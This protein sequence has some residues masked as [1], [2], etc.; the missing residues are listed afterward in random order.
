M[1]VRA[2]AVQ[3]CFA[4]WRINRLRP[5]RSLCPLTNFRQAGLINYIRRNLACHRWLLDR[6]L[7]Q[8]T[9]YL[10]IVSSFQWFFQK[11]FKRDALMLYRY[12]N[13]DFRRGGNSKA[14][15]W[16]FAASNC[17]SLKEKSGH[18]RWENNLA[19]IFVDIFNNGNI[20]IMKFGHLDVI[21]D[22]FRGKL[23][24]FTVQK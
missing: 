11:S 15:K 4:A 7:F 3:R 22:S 16:H 12:N 8:V 6:F 14:E 24:N 20:T 19:R 1:D 5:L 13:W 17:E 9:L 23:G 18:L 10:S 21:I 2:T